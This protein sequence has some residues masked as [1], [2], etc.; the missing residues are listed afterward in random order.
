MNVVFFASSIK[1]E[2]LYVSNRP[3][4]D[5]RRKVRDVQGPRLHP[6]SRSQGETAWHLCERRLI[7]PGDGEEKTTNAKVEGSAVKR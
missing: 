4:E 7:T 1:K 2:L 3:T 6:A 5:Q